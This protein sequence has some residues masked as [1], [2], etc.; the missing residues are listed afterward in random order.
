MAKDEYNVGY[1]KPPTASRFKKGRSGN[2]KGRPKGSRNFK[3]A[4]AEILDQKV[5]V[6]EGGKERRRTVREA[7]LLALSRKSLKGDV[8]AA[9]LL[10]SLDQTYLQE[11]EPQNDESLSPADQAIMNELLGLP[12]NRSAKRRMRPRPARTRRK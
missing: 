7:N 10:I 2:P 12:E 9:A 1:G 5:T 4:L 3:T 8:K 11:E 6:Q